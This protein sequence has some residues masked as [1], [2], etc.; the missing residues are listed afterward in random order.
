[1]G[2][3]A[4]EK[5]EKTI[6]SNKPPVE[7]G[8][9][10]TGFSED[11][12]NVRQQLTPKVVDCLLEAVDRGEVSLQQAED[13]AM[14]LHRRTGGEFKRTKDLAN[15]K[16]DRTSLRQVLTDWFRYDWQ[17]DESGVTFE[18]LQSVLKDIGLVLEKSPTGE[19]VTLSGVHNEEKTKR[20]IGLDGWNALL[21][22][23]EVGTISLAKATTIAEKLHPHTG[24]W[25][26]R[27]QNLPNF[28]FNQKIFK[29]IFIDWVAKINK[30]EL[31]SLT[32]I[33]KVL[34][35]PDLGLALKEI[36]GRELKYQV[37]DLAAKK[38]R[39]EDEAAAK[40][41]SARRKADEEAEKAAWKRREEAEAAA[42]TASERK[43][44]DE[45]AKQAARQKKDEEE[46][47]TK[48]A[49]KRG[50]KQRQLQIQRVN[51]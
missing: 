47:A 39:K 48:A 18:K 20:C 32:V 6:V 34:E 3:A 38:K 7:T 16:Y 4:A 36:P 28:E 51:E 12:R 50:R 19:E 14:G 27:A 46:A 23:F 29:G 8:K 26:R 15:F 17:D 37:I 10:E 40:A 30:E 44:A 33:Q 5:A 42:N 9:R 43:I 45:E 31:I 13:L 35:D 49:R 2:K 41:A 21:E 24:G 22:A 11:E 25:F 1:M